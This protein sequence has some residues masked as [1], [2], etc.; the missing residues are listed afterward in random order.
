MLSGV[1][2]L[3]LTIWLMCSQSR[4][5]ARVQ[6]ANHMF[7]CFLF[8]QKPSVALLPAFQAR[9]R[10]LAPLTL[11]LSALPD[12]SFPSHDS[13]LSPSLLSAAPLTLSLSICLHNSIYT[14]A[15][16]TRASSFLSKVV[17]EVVTPT[18]PDRRNWWEA[19]RCCLSWSISVLLGPRSLFL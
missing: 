18:S 15:T 19:I 9:W 4:F 16:L 11:L 17:A 8:F 5:S 2:E 12:L 7:V 13:S 14:C 10:P 6:S 3:H 1:S